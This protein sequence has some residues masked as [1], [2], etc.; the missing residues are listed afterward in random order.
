METLS[1][2]TAHRW[3]ALAWSHSAGTSPP[4]VPARWA[5]IWPCI[6]VVLT[7]PA[8]LARSAQGHPR[9][10]QNT[11]GAAP[12]STSIAMVL[13]GEEG[14]PR[15]ENAVEEDPPPPEVEELGKGQPP[16]APP[17]RGRRERMLLPSKFP[18]GAIFF[19][20]TMNFAKTIVIYVS[21]A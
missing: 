15:P 17:R 4:S 6:V 3:R 7:H 21:C 8:A 18:M 5:S 12:W 14:W 16:P 9:T 13:G 10:G 2:H 20:D 19:N 11:R 1:P